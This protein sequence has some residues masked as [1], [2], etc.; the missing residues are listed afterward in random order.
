MAVT[1]NGTPNMSVNVAAGRA[2]VL[3][4][5]ATNQGQYIVRNTA[6][7]NVPISASDATNPRRDIVCVRVRDAFYAGSNNDAAIVV[8]EG[9]PAP[10]PVDPTIPPNHL[11]LARVTVAAGATTIVAANITSLRTLV[12][13]WNVAW[14]RVA[15]ATATVDQT[16]IT[17]V[18]D[19][20]GLSVTFTAV[21][22]RLYQA[23]SYGLFSSTTADN[24]VRL[25]ICNASNT[26]LRRGS[27][28]IAVAS[29]GA[30]ATA[31]VTLSG[32]S[33]STTIKCR[34]Q[35]WAGSGTITLANS[36][37]NGSLEIF[38]VGPA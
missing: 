28:H 27:C 25:D 23:V 37:D 24:V 8:V 32:L 7:L 13:P 6:T 2:V 18:V 16:P 1:Q 12:R 21:A 3:G 10:S 9:T 26:V 35:R 31:Q 11:P 34:T 17:T 4:D 19:A 20:T 33:G 30:Q 36:A 15:S 14:G 38:D 5:N 29:A 22:G